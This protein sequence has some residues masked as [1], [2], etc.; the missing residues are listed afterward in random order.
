MSALEACF[1]EMPGLVAAYLYGSYGTPCQTPL[2]D[3]DL[4]LVFHPRARPS[5]R[6]QVEILDRVLVAAREDDVSVVILNGAAP[7]FQFKVLSTGR[8]VYRG[9]PVGLADFIEDVLNS[10]GDLEITNSRFVREYDAALV[11]QYAHD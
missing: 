5:R 6:D 11:T 9:D 10:H 7:S 2:S 1:Q 3:V 4:A 8:L